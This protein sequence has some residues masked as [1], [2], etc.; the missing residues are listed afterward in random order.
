MMDESNV[1]STIDKC[2]PRTRSGY[3]FE[4]DSAASKRVLA[5]LRPGR[6]ALVVHDTVAKKDS[7]EMTEKDRNKLL[8]RVMAASQ[9]RILITHGTD[10]MLQTAQWLQEQ[11][12]PCLGTNSRLVVFTGAFT[13]EAFK[14]SD[15]DFNIG[16]A[17]G[18]LQS[19]PGSGNSRVYIAMNGLVCP[20]ESMERDTENGQFLPCRR[21]RSRDL[22]MTRPRSG[23]MTRPRSGEHLRQRSLES[24]LVD[25]PNQIAKRR[26]TSSSRESLLDSIPEPETEPDPERDREPTPQ[27]EPRLPLRCAPPDPPRRQTSVPVPLTLPRRPG[28]ADQAP[29]QDAEAVF[30]TSVQYLQSQR[31]RSCPQISRPALPPRP[32]TRPA[33]RE[34]ETTS[35]PSLAVTRR[36]AVRTNG[37]LLTSPSVGGVGG[38]SSVG[39]GGLRRSPGLSSL[40]IVDSDAIHDGEA[41]PSPDVVPDDASESPL[42]AQKKMGVRRTLPPGWRHL[43]QRALE[44]LLEEEEGDTRPLGSG[45]RGPRSLLRRLSEGGPI[46]ENIAEEYL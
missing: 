19:L 6:S 28:G 46:T 32:A 3:A 10:T 26:S 29:L 24:L 16:M 7:L 42:L 13:P 43:P 4:I 20:C 34:P 45:R 27:P 18:A 11:L 15:A 35:D 40:P 5:R 1:E 2:Y 39:G 38:G 30:S 9:H 36:P 41:S 12:Q 37:S 8:T 22:S 25:Q 31:A 17:L 33:R 21:P 14:D 44:D 23:E